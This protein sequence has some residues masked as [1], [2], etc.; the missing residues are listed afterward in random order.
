L[1]GLRL[2]NLGII[3]DDRI[4]VE[5]IKHQGEYEYMTN[6]E[7]NSNK[8]TIEDLFFKMLIKVLAIHEL[9]TKKLF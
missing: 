5:D 1:N 3:V 2:Q 4:D 7:N 8:K 9:L 6:I